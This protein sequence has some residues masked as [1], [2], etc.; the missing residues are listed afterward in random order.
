MAKGSEPEAATVAQIAARS[1][2][3]HGVD[4]I[5]GQSLPS[6]L[7]L[8][9]EDEGIRQYVYRTENAGGCMADGYAR[10]SGKIGVVTAQ[11]GPAATLLVAPLA[12]ALK[13]STPI[14]ALVQDVSSA[15]ADRNAF[16][17]FDHFK[18]FDSCAKYIRRVEDPDRIDDFIDAAI[19]SAT[20]G[21]PGPAV[22]LLPVD[23]L[24]K[25]IAVPQKPR[26]NGYGAWP[27]DRPAPDAQSI[28][29][30]ASLLSD[31]E[32]P[33]IIAGGGVHGAGASNALSNLQEAAHL[34]VAYTTMGKGAV[35]DFHPLTV[36]LI[37]NTMGERSLGRWTKPLVQ[38]A[39]VVL[40][41]GT[42][43]NQNG[44]DS[45]SI[46]SKE[47]KVIHLDIDPLEIGRN[48]E[49]SVRLVG[50][51][52]TGLELLLQSIKQKDLTK[53]A[54]SRSNMHADISTAKMKWKETAQSVVQSNSEP[55][56]PERVMN[57]LQQLLTPDTT[58]VAD[59]S[60]SSNWTAAYLEL[61]AGQR[62]LTP[63]GLAGLGWGFPMS[64][65]AELASAKNKIVCLTGDG[66]FGH[67][68]GELETAARN[69]SS[70]TIIVL[71]NGVLGYQRDAETVLFG[72]YTSACH[73]SPV[74]HALI[75]KACGVEGHKIDKPDELSDA[76][77]NA[78]D[79]PNSTLLE[80]IT[81]HNAYPPVTMFD[82]QHSIMNR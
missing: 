49:P 73:F 41:V 70:V 32:N 56:R 6:A 50:D 43:T 42:R 25:T 31:A 82:D 67:C 3:R 61:E 21:R 10:A 1:L 55:I 36:G 37:G 14:L 58:I 44:T 68:W 9:A 19:V 40:F 45:W 52:K 34:P 54:A 48:F 79:S 24:E 13:A 69:G 16:Q 47:A 80:I 35:S 51:A 18:L 77:K 57:E 4:I 11:N 65:G 60:Y 12:E 17:E 76:L 78:I 8:A 27:L 28:D 22:L 59:A 39:D 30:A 26:S 64:L 74:D 71:N 62:L 29:K 63:R 5:F 15:H 7:L 75:A 66:G 53:R 38:N 20:S 81:D 33:L 23:V 46:P 72:R 2:K